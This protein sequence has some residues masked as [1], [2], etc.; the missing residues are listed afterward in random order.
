MITFIV[1]LLILVVGYFVYG[2]YIENVFGP[3]KER[4]TPA[5]TKTDGVD[6]VPMSGKKIFLIQFLNIAGLG[7]IFG[8]I[9]GAMYGPVVFLW[10]VF[11]TLICGAV[12]DYLAAMISVRSGG[13]SLPELIASELG[14]TA[15]VVMRFVTTILMV[16]VG[17]V[18]LSGP[19]NLLVSMT[20]GFLA[21]KWWI[22][23]I[24]IYYVVATL[25]P[26]D[27]I[28]GRIYPI[29]GFALLFMAFGIMGAIIIKGAPVPELFSNFGNL[30]PNPDKFPVFPMLFITVACGAISGF[31]ATQSP[32][33][34]RCIKNEKDGRKV[35]FGAMVAE[36]IVATIWAA[37]GM[38]FFGGMDNFHSFMADNGNSA[39]IVVSKISS[40]WLGKLGG[41]LAL[42]GVVAAPITSAD[43]A[44][45][46][47]RLIIADFL[48]I[49]QK[50]Y[51]KR[52]II[53]APLF[54]ACIV[55]L[56]IN[57]D[58]IW[59]YFAWTNQ[60][61]AVFTLW[62][63]TVYLVRNNKNYFVTLFPAIFMTAVC[64]SYILIAPEGFSLS[65]TIGYSVAVI[66][67]ALL[68]I[69]FA[70]YRKKLEPATIK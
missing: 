16:L 61:L 57:F 42:L 45:R 10:I 7:P 36:G 55:L 37:A 20:G 59:R 34:A 3:D 26:V 38:S 39:A 18:F 17:A 32:L 67:A 49:D 30:N 14:T 51:M 11:G 4:K 6:Y 27:K 66:F 12:H 28:I 21:Y 60:T 63:V 53:S 48:N 13:K 47:A 35:F 19:A 58:I 70:F 29:F 31:H 23:I 68:T 52:I 64:T 24:F 50:S 54:I 44:F 2:R 56:N 46:S 25:F 33:M 9:M 62:S 40:G 65:H 1:C 43:T 41:F 5:F 15:G 8:A 22:A 69:T